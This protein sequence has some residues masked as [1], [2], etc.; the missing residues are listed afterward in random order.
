M[1]RILVV[2]DDV[3]FQVIMRR[4]LEGEGHEVVIAESGDRALRTLR[5]AGSA[6]VVLLDVMMATTLEG[7]DVARE[8]KGD[9][10]LDQVPI[11]MVSS[12][13][14]SPYAAEFPDDE[15]IPIDGWLSKPVQRDVL[16]KTLE[17]FLS[18]GSEEAF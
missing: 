3:D 16:L 12:I 15:H 14:T 5:E 9:P 6:D 13:A 11:I 1:A 2:D 4:M 18:Q 17:R 7:L 10:A 8:I